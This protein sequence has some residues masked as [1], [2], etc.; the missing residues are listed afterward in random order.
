MELFRPLAKFYEL[1]FRQ[2][3][4]KHN[5]IEHVADVAVQGFSGF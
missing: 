5:K 4:G 2:V 1:R 3:P